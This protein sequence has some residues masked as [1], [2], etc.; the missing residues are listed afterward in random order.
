LISFV[1]KNIFLIFCFLA[2]IGFLAVNVFKPV[3]KL[4]VNSTDFVG[5]P[6]LHPIAIN[7]SSY[8]L[9]GTQ[10]ASDLKLAAIPRLEKSVEPTE[11][12]QVITNVSPFSDEP[13]T[14]DPSALLRKLRDWAAKDAEG[15]LAAAMQLPSGDERN[16]ALAAVCYGL[17]E[18]DPADAVNLAQTL[19][20]GEQPGAIMPNLVQQWAT[21]DFQSAFD[22]VNNQ[23]ASEERNDL[24]TRIAYVLSQTQPAEAAGLVMDQIPPGSTQ[25]E[26]VMTVLNQ[27]GNQNLIAATDWV[28]QFPDGPLRERAVRELEGIAAYEQLLAAQ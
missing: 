8:S 2:G 1:N 5:K 13:G 23:A 17:A 11:I 16:Q 3:R 21:T 15:A 27:W 12:V 20:M 25:D 19:N 24:T 10:V 22:W 4:S 18:T 9:A 6:G 26:A 7:T 28:K 14:N